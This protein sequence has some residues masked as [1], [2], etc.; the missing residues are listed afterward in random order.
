MH[1][2]DLLKTS[3]QEQFILLGKKVLE[4]V[5]KSCDQIRI[6]LGIVF[7]KAAP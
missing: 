4:D 7:Q 3:L 2:G 5:S 6:L 1:R